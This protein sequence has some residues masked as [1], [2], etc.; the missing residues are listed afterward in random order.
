MVV[1]LKKRAAAVL[2][3]QAVWRAA[4][5]LWRAA[6]RAREREREGGQGATSIDARGGIDG[7]PE[8]DPDVLETHYPAFLNFM[9]RKMYDKSVE[10]LLI[11]C[12]SIRV[13]RSLPAEEKRILKWRSWTTREVIGW[14]QR[15]NLAPKKKKM[16]I[17]LIKTRA[18]PITASTRWFSV[19]GRAP[20]Q[21]TG[22]A[23]PPGFR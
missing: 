18:C 3:C 15:D 6:Q 8:D 16:G 14:W 9:E 23:D 21:A 22:T 10:A 2:G 1:V 7:G 17:H 20:R 5:C 19:R 4:T 12:E 11:R 13:K